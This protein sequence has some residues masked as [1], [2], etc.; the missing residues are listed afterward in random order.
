MPPA[1]LVRGSNVIFIHR[2]LKDGSETRFC[3]EI[4]GLVSRS[5]NTKRGARGP[6]RGIPQRVQAGLSRPAWFYST[7]TFRTCD[8][9]PSLTRTKYTPVAKPALD[10][11]VV[12]LSGFSWHPPIEIMKPYLRVLHIRA[13]H[14]LYRNVHPVRNGIRT[15]VQ[16]HPVA[17]FHRAGSAA[18]LQII[19]RIDG[20]RAFIRQCG[21]TEFFTIFEIVPLGGKG[22]QL[23]P[24]P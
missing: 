14:I 2:N 9:R 11:R 20:R 10:T 24:T 16:S 17:G 8:P 5:E 1:A 6:E 7:T 23:L 21:T 3:A 22:C 18:R 13:L 4:N 19:R 15:N 12:S